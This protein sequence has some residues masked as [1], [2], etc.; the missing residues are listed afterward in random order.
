MFIMSLPLPVKSSATY[1]QQEMFTLPCQ[2]ATEYACV[3]EYICACAYIFVHIYTCM[4]MYACNK[5]VLE[6]TTYCYI[7]D[8]I[9]CDAITARSV[10]SKHSHSRHTMARPHGRDK[11]VSFVS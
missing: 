3:Y 4:H 9:Q 7:Y 2:V 6:N 1:D 10:F 5:C 8:K 11:G